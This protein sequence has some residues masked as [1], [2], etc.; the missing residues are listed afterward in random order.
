M[1]VGLKA[2]FMIVAF[3]EIATVNKRKRLENYN[4]IKVT[5]F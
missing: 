3:A 5:N 4:E 2:G 1:Q